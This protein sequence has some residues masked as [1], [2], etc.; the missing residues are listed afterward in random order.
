VD[1]AAVAGFIER[2]K[3][4]L[5]DFPADRVINIGETNWKVVNGSFVVWAPRGAESI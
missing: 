3:T 5:A 1:A 4:I 2:V